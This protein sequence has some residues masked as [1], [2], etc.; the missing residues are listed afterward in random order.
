MLLTPVHLSNLFS[1][2]SLIPYYAPVTPHFSL[3][4]KYTMVFLFPLPEANTPSYRWLISHF[5]SHLPWFL[6][7]KVFY[8]LFLYISIQNYIQL[9]EIYYVWLDYLILVSYPL[10]WKL[11]YDWY[12]ILSDKWMNNWWKSSHEYI[13]KIKKTTC[14]DGYFKREKQG[15]YEEWHKLLK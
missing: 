11:P 15:L 12:C 5:K 1:C 6:L 10:D 8:V 7:M 14:K 9:L 2:Q 3:L 13:L 4:L